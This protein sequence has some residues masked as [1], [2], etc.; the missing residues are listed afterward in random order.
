[1]T[2]EDKINVIYNWV[3]AQQ[4]VQQIDIF[5]SIESVEEPTYEEIAED[6]LAKLGISRGISGFRYIAWAVGLVAKDENN[7]RNI[8]VTLYANGGEHFHTSASAFER[9]VRH[10][11]DS[12]LR[13]SKNPTPEA[14]RIFG[15]DRNIADYSNKAVIATLAAEVKK[16][17]RLHK[18]DI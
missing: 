14:I 10:A 13:N 7:L 1:M 8:T 11:I 16:C 2:L 5:G 6:I 3:I 12:T 18:F 15:G 9:G 17:K 4:G